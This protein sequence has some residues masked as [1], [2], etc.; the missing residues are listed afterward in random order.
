M[1]RLVRGLVV[2]FLLV[3]FVGSAFAALEGSK[4]DREIQPAKA[5]VTEST[6]RVSKGTITL[7]RY[8]IPSTGLVNF[9]GWPY[10][11]FYQS[12]I[13]EADGEIRE[14]LF[15]LSDV[16]GVA[17]GNNSFAV[18]LW[19]TSYLTWDLAGNAG[20]DNVGVGYYLDVAGDYDW[21]GTNWVDLNPEWTPGDPLS[22][23]IWPAF[24]EAASVG[25]PADAAIYDTVSA[26]LDAEGTFP[27]MELGVPFVVIAEIQGVSAADPDGRLGFMS[28]DIQPYEY[29]PAMK[30]YDEFSNAGISKYGWFI[31]K[32][33]WDW[34]VEVELTGNRGPIIEHTPLITTV[35][36]DA[37]EVVATITDDNPSGGAAGVASA[38][39][40][41]TVDDGAELE[42]AMTK[43]SGDEYT[44]SIPGQVAGSVVNYKIVATDVLD[45]ASETPTYEYLIFL[46]ESPVLVLNNSG[47]SIAWFNAYVWPGVGLDFDV[48][49]YGPASQDL[50]DNYDFVVDLAG[51]G[52]S[53]YEALKGWAD[54][55]GKHYLGFGDE[56]F[57]YPFGWPAAPLAMADGSFF[58]DVMGVATYYADINV[59]DNDV[60]SIV[61]PIEG[62]VVTGPLYDELNAEIPL[63]V[64]YYWPAA[65]T[66]ELNWFDGFD[67]TDGAV[68]SMKGYAEDNTT[69]YAAGILNETANGT[70]SAFYGLDPLSLNAIS[71][72]IDWWYP[73]YLA[74]MVFNAYFTQEVVVR[75]QV[76]MGVEIVKGAFDPDND[77]VDV[78]GSFNG[79]AHVDED[80][81]QKDASDDDL[82]LLDR[83]FPGVTT[84]QREEYKFVHNGG[85]ADNWESSDNR[86]IVFDGSETI[87]LPRVFFSDVS[88][89]DITNQDVTVIFTVDAYPLKAAL[90]AG[91]KVIDVQSEADT[92]YSYDDVTFIGVNGFF[93]GWPWAAIPDENK[94]FDD[95]QGYDAV[96]GDDVFTGSVVYPA[97]SAKNFIYKYGANGFD[98]EAGFAQNHSAL[99]DDSE[100]TFEL[101]KDC[102][103]MQNQDERLPWKWDTFN[104]PWWVKVDDEIAGVPEVFALRQN[105]PNPFN[106][107]TTI[108]FSIPDRAE[109]SMTIFNV[110][111]QAVRTFNAGMQNVGTYQIVWDGTNDYGVTVPTGVYFYTVRAGQVSATKK[112]VYMK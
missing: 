108:E 111:G 19:S 73:D 28:G 34:M 26:V 102:Y 17:A 20:R 78:R 50:L 71:D 46:P 53:T 29:M 82:F 44:A 45:L 84:G 58:K 64:L 68:L 3:A 76:D 112:M 86:V 99:V 21:R 75:F 5:Q 12:Y 67:K 43:G 52:P 96:A 63:P 25:I 41:Y 39:V 32:Y 107:S 66:G 9:G 69:A 110:L 89:D 33:I 109:V 6:P 103:G 97:Y 23:R 65:I 40:V 91:H 90:N 4:W 59:S 72:S 36:T 42:I 47:Y 95:G 83:T 87:L 37:R 61:E 27:A 104:C 13:P 93:N 54:Q 105:Y 81:L 22:E 88:W 15:R 8:P 14:V 49:A 74:A 2:T 55:G 85:G 24:L 98:N 57:G 106:P 51:H 10:D 80:V 31:R 62:D 56:L 7:M 70:K 38:K 92:I 94:L 35:S 100:A 79:W 101:D 60:P 48:W 1:N 16:T 11:V 18:T 77:V 30:F